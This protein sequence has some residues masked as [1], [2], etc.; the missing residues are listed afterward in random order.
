MRYAQR[1]NLLREY[2]APLAQ[3]ASIMAFI[4]AALQTTYWMFRVPAPGKSVALLGAVAVFLA[5]R[6]EI[7]EIHGSEK[8]LWI[9]VVFVLL[10]VEIRA[11]NYDRNEASQKE[12]QAREQEAANFKKIA[13]GLQASIDNS[14]NQFAATVAQ[15][16]NILD[17]TQSVS[18]LTEKNLKNI[19]GGESF[20][21]VRPQ[22]EAAGKGP[23]GLVVWNHG[24]ELLTGVTIGFS[25][26]N[27]PNWGS[28]FFNRYAVGTIAPHD[29]AMIPV[30]ITPQLGDNG[31]DHYWLMISAQNGTVDETLDFRESK[32][33]PGT[34][35]MRLRVTKRFKIDKNSNASIPVLLREWTDEGGTEQKLPD[36]ATSLRLLKQ[37]TKKQH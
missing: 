27:D 5:L 10:Y 28:E 21:F 25:R 12:R 35:A 20:A 36:A 30:T 19:T 31:I 18:T 4:Y 37:A 26:T 29:A 7:K 15:N 23:I 6:G 2:I 32:K 22:V 8:V 34:Y 1:L 13:D 11:I 14:Q 33:F 3:P 9:M 16:K 17:K 24:E